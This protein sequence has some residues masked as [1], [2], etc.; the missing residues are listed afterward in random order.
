MASFDIDGLSLQELKDLQKHVARM[1]S[2]YEA[3]QKAEARAK[4]DAVAREMGFSL[5]DLVGGEAKKSFKSVSV[6][7]Y[8]NPKDHSAT[9]TGKGRRPAWFAQALDEGVDPDDMLIV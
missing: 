5:T 6:P 7:K 1:I 2:T 3:R 9:W 4:I 8:R